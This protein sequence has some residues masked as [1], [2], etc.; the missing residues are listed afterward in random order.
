MTRTNYPGQMIKQDS[1]KE[2]MERYQTNHSDKQQLEE[3]N[4]ITIEELKGFNELL[5]EVKLSKI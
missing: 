3:S 1:P 4:K 2:H 5:E